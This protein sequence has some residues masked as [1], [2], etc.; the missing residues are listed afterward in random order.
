MGTQTAFEAAKQHQKLFI[1][2]IDH[3]GMDDG[4]D[5]SPL[6]CSGKAIAECPSARIIRIFLKKLQSTDSSESIESIRAIFNEHNYTVTD[7]LNDV[8]HLK[9]EHGV[10]SDDEKF[11]EIFR[12]LTDVLSG[13]PCIVSEC[14]YLQRHYR[15]RGALKNEYKLTSSDDIND[16]VLMNTMSMIHCYFIHSFDLNRLTKQERDRVELLST[17]NIEPNEPNEDHKQSEMNDSDREMI[18]SKRITMMT[19]ILTEKR[20]KLKLIQPLQKYTE[21][22]QIT[23]INVASVDALDFEAISKFTEMDQKVICEWLVSYKT[24]KGQLVHDLLDVIYGQKD[25]I[26]WTKLKMTE[27]TKMELFKNTL[28]GYFESTDMNTASLIKFGCTICNALDLAIDLDDF[29]EIV[30]ARKLDGKMFDKEHR[31]TFLNMNQ[32]AKLFK[33]TKKYKAQPFRVL[34]RKL[35]DWKYIETK[36]PES[37]KKKVVTRAVVESGT[38]STRLLSKDSRAVLRPQS[39]DENVADNSQIPMPLE[40][41]K[42]PDVYEIGRRF[43]FWDSHRKHPHFVM[44]KHEN[45]KE[46]VLHNPKCAGLISMEQWNVLTK[47]IEVMIATESALAIKSNGQYVFMYQIQRNEP[48]DAP[49]LRALK[50]YTDFT[51]LSAAFCA[52]LR[53][54]NVRNIAGVAHW[55]RNLIETVQCFGSP[56][57]SGTE[58]YRGISRAFIFK[59]IRTHF[60]LPFSATSDVCSFHVVF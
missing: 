36:A 19:S 37:T 42:P 52:I 26:L 8:H 20:E 15:E 16:D 21:N 14:Q 50:L 13:N 48:F 4:D 53:G 41:E 47:E 7:L 29:T 25:H 58:Y 9:Y 30:T 28:F 34:Y 5:L 38:L 12:F 24:A 18:E 45:M 46:E 2:F 51:D 6:T 22:A 17:A 40:P 3:I 56:L 49:H 44:A 10:D 31:D 54:G 35:R 60:H 55:A 27:E 33:S 1:K 59:M 32:F 23:Q 39:A 57:Q 43:Y 11:D